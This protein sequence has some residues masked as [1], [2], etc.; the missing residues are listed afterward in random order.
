MT[1]AVSINIRLTP[2]DNHRDEKENLMTNNVPNELPEDFAPSEFDVICG[3]ARQNYHHCES[4]LN[5]VGRMLNPSLSFFASFPFQL[6]IVDFVKSSV[7]MSQ[8]ILLPRVRWK[9][10]K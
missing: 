7:K 10:V 9:R 5:C 6:A 3:W 2:L 4:A 8:D 1:S